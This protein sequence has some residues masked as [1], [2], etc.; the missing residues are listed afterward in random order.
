[1]VRRKGSRLRGR[2][3][4]GRRPI[5]KATRSLI[6][7][8]PNL[9]LLVFRLLRDPR[10]AIADKLLFGAVVAYVLTPFDMLPDFLA[11]LGLVDDLYLL[12]LALSRLLGRAGPDLLI[13]HW[14]GDAGDLGFLIEGVEQIGGVLP[15][16][17]RRTVRRIVSKHH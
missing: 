10:V 11:P 8:L 3:S 5:A 12:G 17:V 1:M 7:Q 15:G 9:L 16:R 14:D 2:R 4:G 6:L 13:Q